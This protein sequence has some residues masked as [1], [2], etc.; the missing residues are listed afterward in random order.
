M[1]DLSIYIKY[2]DNLSKM[3]F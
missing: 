2:L 1:G 3:E